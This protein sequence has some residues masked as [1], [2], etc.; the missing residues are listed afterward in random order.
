[1]GLLGLLSA[2]GHYSLDVPDQADFPEHFPSWMARTIIRHPGHVNCPSIHSIAPLLW[3]SLLPAKH[4]SR[5]DLPY[6]SGRNPVD[7]AGA[8]AKSPGFLF[9]RGT[10]MTGRWSM[11]RWLVGIVD[12]KYD[13]SIVEKMLTL[14]CKQR[15]IISRTIGASQPRFCP[16][17]QRRT[18]HKIPSSERWH[19]IG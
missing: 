2:M 19:S 10:R 8:W 9:R 15:R 14:L 5:P 11:N 3:G 6:S 7:K 17:A 13:K 16:A 4:I 18:H 12:S 1:M